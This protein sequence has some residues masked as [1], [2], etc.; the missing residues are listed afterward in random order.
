MLPQLAIICLQDDGVSVVQVLG[1]RLAK[2]QKT[3]AAQE[4][5][6]GGMMD[7]VQ[8]RHPTSHHAFAGTMDC[9]THPCL[10]EPKNHL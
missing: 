10:R 6:A 5:E 3:I 2:L 8:V 9:L 4:A 1:Q 7:E